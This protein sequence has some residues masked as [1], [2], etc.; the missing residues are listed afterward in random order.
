[1]VG[2]A[3]IW[4][5]LFEGATHNYAILEQSSY[6]TRGNANKAVGVK[7]HYKFYNG[8]AASGKRALS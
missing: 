8:P 2:V 6:E 3:C 1:M 5:F 7:V 4:A